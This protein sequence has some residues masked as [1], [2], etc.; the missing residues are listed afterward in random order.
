MSTSK[1]SNRN[2]NVTDQRHPHSK[3]GLYGKTTLEK[4]R[5]II[6]QVMQEGYSP[7]E[8]AKENRVAVSTVNTMVDAFIKGGRYEA[9][10]KKKRRMYSLQLL[11]TKFKLIRLAVVDFAGLS[12]EPNDIRVYTR[13]FTQIEEIVVD[14]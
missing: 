6:D 7:A 4:R 13:K 2:Q 3:R 14:R 5:K 10:K 12:T 11:K 9:K 8:T 1:N